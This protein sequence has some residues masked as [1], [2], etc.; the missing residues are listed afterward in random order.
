[1]DRPAENELDYCFFDYTSSLITINT[2]VYIPGFLLV[3]LC[4]LAV[5]LLDLHCAVHLS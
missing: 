5:L 2:V 4:H 3:F 1:M